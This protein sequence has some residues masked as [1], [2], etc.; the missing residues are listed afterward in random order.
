MRIDLWCFYVVGDLMGIR[1][2]ASALEILDIDG[3][4][5]IGLID[6]INFARRLKKIHQSSPANE[7]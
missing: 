6:F 7:Y 1:D 3:D 2:A 4:S 5:K